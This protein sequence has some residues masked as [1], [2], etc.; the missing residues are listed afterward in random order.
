MRR[1]ASWPRETCGRALPS[2]RKKRRRP[3]ERRHAERAISLGRGGAIP[4][5]LTKADALVL[6]DV[7][8]DFLPGG[9]LGVPDGDAVVP[10][11]NRYIA[12]AREF[13]VPIYATRDW[14]PANHCSFEAQ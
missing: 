12:L 14:H 13:G 11:L 5:T 3:R 4:V 7:Q 6:V 10:V 1:N 2:W 8:R 9:A